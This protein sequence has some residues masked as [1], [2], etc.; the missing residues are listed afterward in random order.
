MEKLKVVELNHTCTAAP[1]QYSG[2]LADGR[3]IYIRLRWNILRIDVNGETI[4]RREFP[5]YKGT[6]K[7]D[8]LKKL[9]W[10]DNI[11]FALEVDEIGMDY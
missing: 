1:D 6:I 2:K 3:E 11:L 8:E 7:F 9:L 4:W 10:Q 5:Y